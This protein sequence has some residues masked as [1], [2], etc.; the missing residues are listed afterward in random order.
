MKKKKKSAPKPDWDYWKKMGAVSLAEATM[1]S[2][3]LEPDDNFCHGSNDGLSEGAFISNCVFPRSSTPKTKRYDLAVSTIG[4][5][6]GLVKIKS[7]RPGIPKMMPCVKLAEYG[8][9]AK[10]IGIDLP[11]TFPAD[12]GQRIL[13]TEDSVHLDLPYECELISGLVRVMWE[14]FSNTDSK[15]PPKK[16]NVAAD[17]VKA[18]PIINTRIASS[19]ASWITPN[20]SMTKKK[21]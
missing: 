16:Y 21:G 19:L 11:E 15:N 7:S 2:F 12:R 1:L 9:W 8:A 6:Q 20:T 18:M 4:Q 14:N 3:D 10:R 5:E 13:P 17:I